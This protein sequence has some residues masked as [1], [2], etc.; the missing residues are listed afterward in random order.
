[1]QKVGLREVP[2]SL[3]VDTYHGGNWL[4]DVRRSFVPE[5]TQEELA[6]L[7]GMTQK[8]VSRIENGQNVKIS[9]EYIIRL[10][11]VLE[12]DIRDVIVQFIRWGD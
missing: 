11:Y 5:L 12:Q 1:M 9:L 7:A 8:E 3:I 10:A 2:T 6:R 4:R